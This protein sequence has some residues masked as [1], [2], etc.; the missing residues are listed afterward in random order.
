MSLLV[1]SGNGKELAHEIALFA[2]MPEHWYRLGESTWTPG[3]RAGY[4]ARIDAYQCCFS[5]TL[6]NGNLHRHL[7][8][9]VNRGKTLPHP[10]AFFT[11]ASWF[12]FTGGKEHEGVVVEA[13][14]DW[15]WGAN[16][17]APL[18]HVVLVQKIG[19][20]CEATRRSA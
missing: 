14:E 19:P 12:G 15:T 16:E 7:S 8:I 11:I 9:S 17:K 3:E 18:P 6:A 20:A 1:L 2:A 5:Y 10:F 4:V 13:A